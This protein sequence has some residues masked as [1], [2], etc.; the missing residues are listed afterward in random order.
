MFENT[1][2]M[3]IV[4]THSVTLQ[5]LQ[6]PQ[7]SPLLKSHT[8]ADSGLTS[9]FIQPLFG[10][11]LFEFCLSF[12]SLPL[13]HHLFASF[14][15]L[16]VWKTLVMCR[17][18]VRVGRQAGIPSNHF[19]RSRW[20]DWTSLLQACDSHRHWIFFFS[21]FLSEHLF[22][23]LLS[24][25]KEHFNKYKKKIKYTAYT[26]LNKMCKF[27]LQSNGKKWCCVLFLSP[28]SFMSGIF[29]YML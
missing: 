2:N 5:A 7:V 9:L 19:I 14:S 27:T 11:S 12:L 1:T 18:R 22:C 20:N 3:T 28:V 23:W 10:R 24:G 25:C 15:R 21:F 13:L 4:S 26:R 29:L 16:A 6:L 8:D 17:V